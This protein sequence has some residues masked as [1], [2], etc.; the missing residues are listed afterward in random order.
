M[1]P[2]K[3]STKLGLSHCKRMKT[4]YLFAFLLA[5]GAWFS[6]QSTAVKADDATPELVA[7]VPSD[8]HSDIL[9]KLMLADMA[10]NQNMPE[11]AL[12][13][14]LDLSISTQ[15]PAIAAYTT[16][17]AIQFQAP[18][19][20][21]QSAEIW[22]KNA[23]DDLQAQMVAS[24]L[25][26]GGSIERAIPYLSRAIELDPVQV[27]QHMMAIQARLSERSAAHLKMA[28]QRIAKEQSSNAYAQLIAAQ[29][30]AQQGDI[31]QA[32]QLVDESLRLNPELTS[33]IELKARLI[34]YADDS[35][36]AALHYL[37]EKVAKYPNNAEL[38]LFY[39]SALMDANRLQEATQH[40]SK[41]T[42]DKTW[43]GHA[44][45][46]LG[47][48]YF[49]SNQPEK[50]KALFQKALEYDAV[51][52]NAFYDLG[53][54]SEYQKNPKDA[55]LYY[56]SITSGAFHVPA[57][58]RAVQLLKINKMYPEAIQV[59]HSASPTTIDEQKQ[60]LLSEVDILS[61]S[62]QLDEAYSL[63]DEILGKLPEDVDV[64]FSHGIV[65]TKLKKWPVA[66]NDL[67][68]LLKIDPNAADAMNALGYLLS[69]QK[70]RYDEAKQYLNQA[71]TLAPKNPA[72]LDTM[73][74][75]EYQMGDLKAAIAHLKQAQSLSQ[76][77]EIAAHLGEV[78]WASGKKEDAAIV[79]KA[80]YKKTPDNDVLLET[81]DRLKIDRPRVPGVSG[82][83]GV[84]DKQS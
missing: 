39:A 49:K 78:L 58:L 59:L 23:Q 75:L 16:E 63:I 56:T 73:G 53:E 31:P 71:L 15:D 10:S 25:L 29:S 81:F 38:R 67:K 17:L 42:D 20:A 66:E 2:P 70:D 72:Y 26:I 32:N 27:N 6:L 64:L 46:F 8:Q 47:E 51:R 48:V 21:V 45:L 5:T 33:A 62:K 41:L 68:T 65:A 4:V 36:T 13:T 22:A 60:L 79:L 54:L 34:R 77:S 84:K 82:V 18:E 37:N 35:D 83:P 1:H 30:T 19:P 9:Y 57:T 12:K 76:D 24:T 43:G 69:L 3:V 50:S 14:A 52:D 11:E 40:L 61:S 44:S 55:V 74:W 28:L 80:A 7:I